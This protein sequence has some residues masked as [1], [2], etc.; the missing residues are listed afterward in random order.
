MIGYNLDTSS[1]NGITQKTIA[2]VTKKYG[3]GG[4]DDFINGYPKNIV[5]GLNYYRSII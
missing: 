3:F 1:N 5:N 4:P 2:D